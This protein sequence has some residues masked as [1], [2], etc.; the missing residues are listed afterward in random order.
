[1]GLVADTPRAAAD[2]HNGLTGCQP[3]RHMGFTLG[4]LAASTHGELLDGDPGLRLDRLV[5]DSRD[6]GPGALFVA[7]TGEAMDGHEFIEVAVRQG[8]SALLC[9]AVPP[10][11]STARVLVPDTT[12]A[13]VGFGRGRLA[14]TRVRVVAVTGSAGKTTTKEMVAS[15]LSRAHSVLR[16][17]NRN[18]YTGLAMNLAE[19]DPGRDV[20]VGEYG[21]DGLGQI[22][23][24][25]RIA[26][27]DVALVLNV[28]LAHVGL[29]GS[30]EAV[31][32]AKRELVEAVPSDGVAL[33]NADDPRVTAMAGVCRG[34]V[35][36]FGVDS[37][38]AT[39][40]YRA[41]DVELRGLA[42]STFTLRTPEGDAAIVLAVPGR[43]AVSNAV[44][45][46]GAGHLLGVSLE[47][48]AAALRDFRPVSG[49]LNLR[50]GRR[51]A[52]IID[53][54]YNAS[55]GSMEASLQVLASEPG[56]T[57]IA[58]LGDMLE[59]GDETA[60][61]HLQLGRAAGSS[62]DLLVVLGDCAETVLEG[63]R[64]AGMA[65]EDMIHAADVDAAVES[66]EARLE[67]AVV[68]V[69]ASRGMA[70]DRVVE[71]LVAP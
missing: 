55:P 31:A 35:V 63:A 16:G 66:V 28:G 1:M 52:T 59:L 65:A 4:E 67:G 6:A 8:A 45:A 47:D 32:R 56:R 15:V 23:F 46:A 37:K 62:A 41:D 38:A 33:L 29:L 42:G 54:A 2:L 17:D 3:R 22:A 36:Y 60:E 13:L 20:F 30:I 24:L 11:V 48:T 71:R 12:E 58:V 5:T 25:A 50:S 21:M 44:A 10:G 40:D 27:P 19:L 64:G 18:T 14:E 39:V 68:L 7:L 57:R 26:P 9:R 51:G 43:H 69:K 53:D 49:R 34:N 70:L 61:A